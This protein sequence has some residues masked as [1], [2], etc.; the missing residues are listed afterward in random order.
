MVRTNTS[1]GKLFRQGTATGS[2]FFLV[3]VSYTPTV[4]AKAKSDWSRVQKVAPRTKT[5]VMLYTDRV[6][7]GKREVKGRFHSATPE[8]ITVALKRGQM[9]TL[10]K[11]SV[12][13]VLVDRL[14]YEGLITAGASTA[15]FLGLAPGWDLNSRGWTLLGGLFVGV[16]TGIAFLLAP[17]MKTIYNMPRKLRDDPPPPPTAAKQSSISS[18]S[19]LLLLEDKT[20]GPELGR[21]QNRRP[22]FR[23]KLLLDL[24][25]RPVRAPRSGID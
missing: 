22:L 15:I 21:S 18:G 24:S 14:P 6:S 5:T 10:G 2:V 20:S 4:A 1:F 9:R 17:K 8:F 23:E 25:S 11:Q 13:K 16:P 7:Q 19:G 3:V 12:F